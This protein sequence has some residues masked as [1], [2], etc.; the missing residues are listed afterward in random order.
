MAVRLFSLKAFL[1][2]IPLFQF[3]NK[4]LKHCFLLPSTFYSFIQI[5][6]F[7]VQRHATRRNVR[8]IFHHGLGGGSYNLLKTILDGD[9]S[10]LIYLSIPNPRKYGLQIK[11]SNLELKIDYIF[12]YVF[13][14]LIRILSPSNE[15]IINHFSGL[16][17]I[18]FLKIHKEFKI[19][20]IYLHDYFTICPF[21]FLSPNDVYCGLPSETECNECIQK[22]LGASDRSIQKHRDQFKWLLLDPT[23]EIIVPNESVKNHFSKIYPS[24][25]VKILEPTIE[26]KNWNRKLIINKK[27][28]LFGSLYPH[29]GRNFVDKFLDYLSFNGIERKVILIGKS[30]PSLIDEA[31]FKE[32]GAYSDDNYLDNE[33]KQQGVDIVWFPVRIP[34]TFSLT[35]SVA[36]ENN[37]FIFAPNIGSFPYRLKDYPSYRLF[38]YRSADDEVFQTL[39]ELSS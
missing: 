29:K 11:V 21:Y 31:N 28:Y 22:N 26:K 23:I 2:K 1:V 25:N 19:S 4:F 39:L 38:D 8:L 37:L 20:T 10:H 9:D 18:N 5:V 27:I 15:I 14:R 35:L 17:L 13:I 32:T 24:I 34:E 7:I 36:M 6:L 30:H 3:F 12:I 33:I 16:E